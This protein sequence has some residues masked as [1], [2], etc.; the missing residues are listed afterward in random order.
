MKSVKAVRR[1]TNDFYSISFGAKRSVETEK[2]KNIGARLCRLL[3]A[4]PPTDSMDA[5]TPTP[6]PRWTMDDGSLRLAFARPRFFRFHR[7][8]PSRCVF[9]R[10]LMLAERVGHD[11]GATLEVDPLAL[12]RDSLSVCA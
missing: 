1:A 12:N 7:H 9:G 3:T 5:C 11:R 10:T 2:N 6:N 4:N 8:L